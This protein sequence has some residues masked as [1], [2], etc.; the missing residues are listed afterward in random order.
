MSSN[1]GDFVD[2]IRNAYFNACNFESLMRG[3]HIAVVV[4]ALSKIYTGRHRSP[5][6]H[7]VAFLIIILFTLSTIHN[8]TYWAYVHRAF[9][10]H[11]E[12]SQ[13]TA[14]AL[15][16]Y[17]TWF[18]GLTSVSDVN[19][20][21]ADCIIIRR[22]WV[23]WG[24]DYRVIILP[25]IST[26]LMTVF[27]ILAIY[28]TVTFTTFGVVGVDYA[29]ALYASTFST[30]VICTIAIVYKVLKV[31]GRNN[32]RTYQGVVE[33]VVESSV[34]YCIATLFALITYVKSGPASEFASAFWTSVTGIAPTLLVARVASGEARPDYTWNDTSKHD[35]PPFLRWG[36]TPVTYAYEL[37]RNRE[38]MTVEDL[39]LYDGETS[40]LPALERKT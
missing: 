11:G 39:S 25:V 18:I 28:Q 31:G 34:L 17:P 26:M 6:R 8:A 35:S 4:N 24:P 23:V 1:D 38:S 16:E 15:N 22:T 13:S 12:T 33:V 27:S 7:V 21:L 32:L 37:H 30:T 9:I 5:R 29:T 19:A 3:I 14:N 36:E 40:T 20:I 2:Q 10:S